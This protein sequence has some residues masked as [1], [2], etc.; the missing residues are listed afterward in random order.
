[1]DRPDRSV[2]EKIVTSDDLLP[3]GKS[4]Y[5]GLSPAEIDQCRYIAAQRRNPRRSST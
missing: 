5:A 3:I 2:E 1:M 4:I